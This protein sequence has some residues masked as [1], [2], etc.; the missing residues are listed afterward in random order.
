MLNDFVGDLIAGT[1]TLK[2][3]QSHKI[4]A[5]A[6]QNTQLFVMRMCIS[7]LIITV[8]KWN[9][10]YERYKSIIP[11]NIGKK[12]K[13]LQKDIKRRGLVSF[14]NIVVGHIWD[15]RLNRP[16]T[17]EEIDIKL[18][19][20]FITDQKDFLDWVNNPKNQKNTIVDM[21][22]TLRTSLQEKYALT[23]KKYSIKAYS[24]LL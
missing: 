4:S 5:V 15:K 20:V 17:P 18:Q 1:W 14:R 22:E 23:E 10:F 19:K 2:L 24:K 6:N 16:L 21:C 9:E 11:D 13:I 3:Y 8:S 7:H 12:A